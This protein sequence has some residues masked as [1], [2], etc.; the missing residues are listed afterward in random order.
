M[1]PAWCPNQR[2]YN[3]ALSGRGICTA[4]GIFPTFRYERPFHPAFPTGDLCKTFVMLEKNRESLC[5]FLP[6]DLY[7]STRYLLSLSDIDRSTAAEWWLRIYVVLGLKNS[8]TYSSEYASGF[9]SLRSCICLTFLRLVTKIMSNSPH[10]YI[11]TDIYQFK[12]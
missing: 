6:I 1:K 12:T 2:V 11:Y 9:L 5:S 7:E 3:P 8:S 4:R 10:E